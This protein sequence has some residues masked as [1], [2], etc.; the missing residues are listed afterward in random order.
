MRSSRGLAKQV[1]GYHRRKGTPAAVLSQPGH[2][3]HEGVISEMR[4]A[5]ALLI[6]AVAVA[7]VALPALA[8]DL[9]RA[10]YEPTEADIAINNTVFLRIRTAAAGFTVAQREKIINERLVVILS[11]HKP[12]PVTISSING[13]P[14]IYVDGVQLVTVYPQDGAANKAKSLMAVAQTWAKN[15]RVGLPKV[16]PGAHPTG[17]AR[18]EC[19]CPGGAAVSASFD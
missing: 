10:A 12:G 11:C 16:M 18:P 15:L 13:K 4:I 14:T 6:G 8:Q 2:P 5:V 1:R 9:A 19:E 7:V 3:S 17:P